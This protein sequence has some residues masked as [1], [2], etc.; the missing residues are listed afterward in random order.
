MGIHRLSEVIKEKAPKGVKEQ[1]IEK[2]RG[3]KVAIDASMILYQTLIAIRYGRDSLLNPEGNTTAHL[4][5]I[6]Y[7]SINLI[8]KGIVP[9]FV[10]DGEPPKLKENILQQRK[11]R[12]QMAE[13][14][15]LTAATEELLVKHAK[16]AVR[17]TEYH[18]STSQELLSLLGIP[19]ITAPE[20]AEAFCASLNKNN[21]VDAI[22]S[23]DMDSLAFGGVKLLRNFMPSMMNKG[24][25]KEY[26]LKTILQQMNLE[27]TEFIDLCILLGSD[28]CS[29]PK[30]IGPKRAYELISEYKTIDALIERNKIQPVEQWEYKE[31]QKIFLQ[32]YPVP[33]AP[34]TLKPFNEEGL[35]S[36][37]VT[38]N[39]FDKT[40]IETA[41]SRLKAQR[42]EQ[43]QTRLTSFFKK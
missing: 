11:E 22:I 36:F 38:K 37:L 26:T 25:I 5:G 43:K 32:E 31:A 9:L 6:L 20:E 35:L 21:I 42:K 41:I 10:F 15:L 34:F 14:G 23:E 19:F 17:V 24:P 28:Y 39:N 7:K 33:K 18:T 2:Y 8:E 40:K 12:K 16:R 13:Q 27:Q 3:Q 1:R 4:Q 30:G 29:T